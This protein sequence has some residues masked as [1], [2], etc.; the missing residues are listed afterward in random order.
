MLEAAELAELETNT[1]FTLAAQNSSDYCRTVLLSSVNCS[2]R[3]R[4]EQQAK[5]SR[6]VWNGSSENETVPGTVVM[7][8]WCYCTDSWIR[9]TGHHGR[10]EP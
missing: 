10:F 6:T 2:V 9:E 8:G 1:P 7:S 5:S 4:G 3:S